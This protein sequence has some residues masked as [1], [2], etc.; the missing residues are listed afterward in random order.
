MAGFLQ[1]LLPLVSPRASAGLS[2]VQGLFKRD[3]A[4]SAGSG[5]GASALAADVLKTPGARKQEIM[6]LVLWI[7]G[8]VVAI[9]LLM[10]GLTRRKR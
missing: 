2:I 9:G 6:T 3:G 10:W 4:S 5:G 7:G 1:K 8:G